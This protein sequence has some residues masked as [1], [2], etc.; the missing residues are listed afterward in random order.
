MLGLAAPAWAVPAISAISPTNGPN[1]CVV[2]V[3]GT[4]FAEFPESQTQVNFVSGATVIPAPPASATFTT[5]D[6]TTLWVVASGLTA[7]TSYTVR[8]TNPGTPA[9]TTSTATFLATSAAGGCAPTITSFTPTCGAAGTTVVIT[10]TNLIDTDLDGA[11]VYFSPYDTATPPARLAAHSVPDVDDVTSLS[12]VVPSTTTTATN[13][14]TTDGPIKVITD[15]ATG[16]TAFS[17]TS[18]LVP[19]PDCVAAAGHSR[20]ISLKLKDKLVAKGTVKSTETTPFTACAQS[21][22]IQSELKEY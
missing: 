4:G 20:S 19:P 16:G 18:F 3:T 10:G 11:D 14:G 9:G 15:L 6:D 2:V 1:N 12:V 5:I 13:S 8:V 17:T 7:G 21:N 22:K